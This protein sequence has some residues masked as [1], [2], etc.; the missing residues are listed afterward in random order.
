MYVIYLYIIIEIF[1]FSY[2]YEVWFFASIISFSS[3]VCV[4][5][6]RGKL[7]YEIFAKDYVV[8]SLVVKDNTLFILRK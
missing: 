7:I 4:H 8:F 6:N 2:K 1:T 3:W 5:Q